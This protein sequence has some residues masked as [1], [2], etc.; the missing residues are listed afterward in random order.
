MRP[1]G[2]IGPSERRS[3]AGMR[4]AVPISRGQ[5]MDLMLYQVVRCE[6]ENLPCTG[7]VRR[8]RAEDLGGSADFG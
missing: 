1:A 7:P 6:N 4:T 8:I 2:L 5:G 3:S